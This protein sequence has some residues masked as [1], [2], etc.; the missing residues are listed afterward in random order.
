M[1]I[2][3]KR[4]FDKFLYF[5]FK[6]S[7]CLFL[8]FFYI[9][10]RNLG[11]FR[12]YSQYLDYK[13]KIKMLYFFM[14]N[15]VRVN[16][17]VAFEVNRLSKHFRCTDERTQTF[18]DFRFKASLR[19]LFLFYFGGWASL[20]RGVFSFYYSFVYI[21]FVCFIFKTILCFM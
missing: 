8:K 1:K 4:N 6:K 16:V 3:V 13:I 17:C 15:L 10:G 12:K 11:L 2:I 21:L 14:D 7:Y 9:Y 5:M 19:I 20:E 18:L